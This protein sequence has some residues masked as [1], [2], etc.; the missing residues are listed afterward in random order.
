[1]TRFILATLKR[2]GLNPILAHYEPYGMSPRL[3]TPAF[4]LGLRRPGVEQRQAYGGIETHAIGAWLPELEFTHFRPGLAWRQLMDSCNRF[5]AV[6]GNVLAATPFAYSGRPFLAWVATGWQ[7]D[8]RDRV[9]QFPM[10]RKLLDALLSARVLERQERKVLSS[11]RILALS[12]QTRRV[13]DSLVGGHIVSDVLPMP[14]DVQS[15]RPEKK[16]L[17]KGRIGF[18]GRFNDPRKNIGILLAAFSEVLK[19]MPDAELVLVG[20]QADAETLQRVASLGITNGVRFSGFLCGDDLIE[21]L[22]SLDVFAVPSH[23]EGL[24]IAALEAMACGCPVV[25]TRCGGP[26]EFVV[27]G[28]TGYLV[29]F[30]AQEMAGAIARIIGNRQ[31]RVRLGQT[32]RSLVSEKYNR[33]RCEQI[34]WRTFQMDSITNKEEAA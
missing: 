32:A 18:S 3:S 25:S 27:D 22:Q 2:G 24:C 28:E 8:R 7:E 14:I 10:Y 13:L 33:E 1:M 30:D 29:G 9:R 34:F 19:R 20:A 21:V 6:S 31:L 12:D 11:G 17:H 23:Q 26:E 4:A 5:V 16:R 15:F